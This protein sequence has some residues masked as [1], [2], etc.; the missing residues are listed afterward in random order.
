LKRFLVYL[1][2]VCTGSIASAAS[3]DCGKASTNI[4]TLICRDPILSSLDDRLAEAYRVLLASTDTPDKTKSDQR[5]WLS[6]LGRNCDNVE[7]IRVEYLQRINELHTDI[8][9]KNSVPE[10]SEEALSKSQPQPTVEKTA[11]VQVEPQQSIQPPAV[12]VIVPPVI[13]PVAIEVASQPI[14]EKPKSAAIDPEQSD[15]SKP[16]SP[17]ADVF[18]ALLAIFAIVLVAA[19]IRPKWVLRWKTDPTRKHV[20]IY[21]LPVGLLLGAIADLSRTDERK[22]YDVRV[23]NEKK[24][25]EEH[26]NQQKNAKSGGYG[27]YKAY[28]SMAGNEDTANYNEDEYLNGALLSTCNINGKPRGRYGWIEFRS[29]FMEGHRLKDMPSVRM[30][31][32]AVGDGSDVSVSWRGEQYVSQLEALM[33]RTC[34]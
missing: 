23:A 17:L 18:G 21:L 4:E 29:V 31:V 14:P 22:A 13:A 8:L 11:S 5:K 34:D 27:L 2:V 10:P 9:R 3:F 30:Y 20:A 16:S 32:F 19:L 6:A 25:Q 15:S 33:Q 7:C 24:A 26:S 12:D 28:K 1:F